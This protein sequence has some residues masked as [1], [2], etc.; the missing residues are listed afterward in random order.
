[1]DPENN[2]PH[3]TEDDWEEL[4]YFEG[5]N[6][7]KYDLG[8]EAKKHA[9]FAR[10]NWYRS[11]HVMQ[12]DGQ[13]ELRTLSVEELEEWE[14]D[15]EPV[16]LWASQMLQSPA[17]LDFIYHITYSP[18]NPCGTYNGQPCSEIVPTPL[19]V[20]KDR[21]RR[22]A[23]AVLA[24]LAPTIELRVE[25]EKNLPEMRGAHALTK[26]TLAN[27]R[28]GINIAEDEGA[29]VGM[30]S[31]IRINHDELDRLVKLR[32][33]VRERN[34]DSFPK[35]RHPSRNDPAIRFRL[36]FKLAMTICHEI[37]HAI[38]IALDGEYFRL[39]RNEEARLIDPTYV[40]QRVFVNEPYFGRD[41]VAELGY[42]WENHVFGGTVQLGEGPTYPLFFNKGPSY[43][44]HSDFPYRKYRKSCTRYV[45]SMYYVCNLRRH[46]VWEYIRDHGDVSSLYIQKIIGYKTFLNDPNFARARAAQDP[47]LD[48]TDSEEED[49]RMDGGSTRRVSRLFADE[50]DP[51]SAGANQV[52]PL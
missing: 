9:I 12:P 50:A 35:D 39:Y 45:V 42:A 38:E 36:Q 14:L 33:E 46:D 2:F 16:E 47:D 37:I 13:V 21:R 1:M 43:L 11:R 18:R 5:L 17:S 49:W 7:E 8:P 27:A 22:M 41:R 20:H 40:A 48:S 19:K 30:A 26:A 34:R 10:S 44:N 4:G 51:S 23:K 32:A 25:H 52:A 31:V 6:P 3:I 24:R 15:F 28:D 29:P